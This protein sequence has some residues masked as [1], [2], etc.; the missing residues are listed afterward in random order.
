MK[1]TFALL[2]ALI[3]SLSIVAPALAYTGVT[4]D[5]ID[6]KTSQPWAHG[7]DVYLRDVTSN[8]IIATCTIDPAGHIVGVGGYPAPCLYG[9]NVIYAPSANLPPAG[10]EVKVII[11][12]SCAISSN[13]SGGP[14]GT[15]A[16]II[17]FY[18][19]DDPVSSVPKALPPISTGTGPNAVQL[20]GM[21][22]ASGLGVA[23]VLAVV[24]SGSL[25]VNRTSNK[26]PEI[27]YVS[28]EVVS[29][30][31]LEVQAGSPLGDLGKFPSDDLL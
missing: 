14:A 7:G 25:L 15:P 3:L 22:G 20:A 2:I 5:V 10:G 8:T 24:A 4:G 12:F 21:S 30:G 23:L 18:F 19:E 29:E 11:D 6:S 28:P 26:E 27:A 13:C 1:K 31:V 16:P 17:T 9:A